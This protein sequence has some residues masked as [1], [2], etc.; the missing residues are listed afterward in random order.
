[1]IAGDWRS[2]YVVEV[3][4]VVVERSADTVN[5][6]MPNGDVEVRVETVMTVSTA[7]TPP[8]LIEEDGRASEELRLRE[9]FLDLRRPPLQEALAATTPVGDGDARFAR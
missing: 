5:P 3:R 7:E 1:M 9:R 2:E 8:F 4:G 6:A